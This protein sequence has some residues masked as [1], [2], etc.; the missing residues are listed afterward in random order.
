[1]NLTNIAD[2]S[3]AVMIWE[4]PSLEK[5]ETELERLPMVQAGVLEYEVIPLKPYTGL[6]ELFAN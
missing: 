6:A 2:M 5:V 4:L 3:G 1:M